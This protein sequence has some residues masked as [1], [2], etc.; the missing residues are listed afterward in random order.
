MNELESILNTATEIAE[1]ASEIALSYFRQAIL[2]EMKENMTPVTVADKKTEENIR[3]ELS[4]AFPGFGICGEEF[5]EEGRDQELVWTV[6]P[7]DGT[8]SFIKGI[9]LFGTLLGLLQHG[10][11]ILGI[12]VLPALRETYTAAK[13]L[14]TFCNGHQ[15]HVSQKTALESSFVSIADID[16]F[17]ASG[18]K[19]ALPRLMER[20]EFVRG[21]TDCFGHSCVMRGGIDAM[22]DPVVS[23]WDIAP[24]ACLIRE[25]GGEYFSLNGK[26][27]IHESSFVTCSPGL[28]KEILATLS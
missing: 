10:E 2:I 5:G 4:L 27:T 23:L 9:P 19:A 20:A 17:E 6:D 11:P 8:K 24:L 13:G 26:Q 1:R 18:R 25:A 16:C 14:G 7:I 12:M 22:I 21:Y 15:L 28:K 3:E